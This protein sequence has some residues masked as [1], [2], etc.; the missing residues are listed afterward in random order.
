MTKRARLLASIAAT[1]AD[2]RAGEIASLGSAHID[3]W[4]QQFS[5]DI[6]EP[7]LSELDHVLKQTYLK[8]DFASGFLNKLLVNESLAGARPCEFWKSVNFLDIQQ[9]GHSQHEMLEMFSDILERECGSAIDSCG[10]PVRE[11]VY[12][13]DVMFSGNRVGNDLASWIRGSAPNVAV[14][15]VILVALHTSGEWLVGNRLKKEIATSGKQIAIKYWRAMSVENRK[16]YKNDSEVLWPADL[17]DDA[18]LRAYL[19]LP[20]KFPFAPRSPGGKLG[21]FSSE[22]ARQLLERELLLA[23]VKIRARCANPK[24][25]MRPLGFSPFGLGF[26]SMIVTFRNCPNNCP[27]ALWWGDRAA[28]ASNPL[29]SWYPLFP[30]KTYS[31]G[32][33]LDDFSS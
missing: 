17:P 24:D 11:F 15:N 29:S 8:R 28:D 5:N 13:D 18:D 1:V 22:G 25:I 9:N 16:Y 31:D 19:A 12:L 20:H 32:F 4:V 14:V 21:P 30:R 27:L 7:L 23:G 33:S 10:R 26:G 6:Q 2:Y 3:R